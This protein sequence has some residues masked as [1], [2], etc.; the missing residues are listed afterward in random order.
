[1]IYDLARQWQWNFQDPASPL[2]EGLIDLHHN[3]LFVL[4]L[5]FGVVTSLM[6]SI[7][8]DT[9]YIWIKPNKKNIIRQK[10]YLL[11]SN[12]NHG[13]ILEIVWTLIPSFI[14]FA[15]AIPSFALL[16]SM[17]EIFEPQMT[18]KVIAN[19]WYW[20]FEYGNLGLE[21]DSYMIN[22]PDLV[23][24]EPR[25]LTVDNPLFIPVETNVRL[26][27]TSKDV[28]HA[29]AVPSLGLKVDAVPGRLNQLSC[30]INRPGIYYGQCSELCGVNHA[31]MPLQ[32]VS[33]KFDTAHIKPDLPP[34]DRESMDKAVQFM[35]KNLS[36]RVLFPNSKSPSDETLLCWLFEDTL[37]RYMEGRLPFTY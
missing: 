26:L 35:L 30:Y 14:L 2:M 16:Y 11:F 6:I 13:T 32:V 20:S 36:P 12:L 3:I 7:I 18:I 23:E 21:W 29:F 34:M 25:L 19:Q 37:I 22:E 5:I 33:L 28:I 10:Q 8:K 17:E 1:M 24:G 31:F 15:I 9:S 4:I 27:I